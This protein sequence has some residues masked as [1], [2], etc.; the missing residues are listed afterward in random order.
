MSIMRKIASVL[1][2]LLFSCSGDSDSEQWGACQNPQYYFRHEIAIQFIDA[3]TNVDL[4]HSGEL[5]FE[6]L[7]VTDLSNSQ[8]ADIMEVTVIDNNGQS[9]AEYMNINLSMLESEHEPATYQIKKDGQNL[10][11]LT[12]DRVLTQEGCLINEH[13]SNINI[14]NFTFTSDGSLVKVYM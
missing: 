9:I 1:I 5:N 11:N 12:F 2:L 10:F 7:S 3:E 8:D 13:F 6:Q 4:L 14:D